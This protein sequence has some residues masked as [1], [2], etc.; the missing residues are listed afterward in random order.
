MFDMSNFFFVARRLKNVTEKV[1]SMLGLVAEVS[2]PVAE[3][4]GPCCD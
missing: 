4:L 2:T 3:Q 1:G